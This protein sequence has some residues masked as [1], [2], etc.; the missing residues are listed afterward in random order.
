MN[1]PFM[2]LKESISPIYDEVMA[3]IENLIK[4]TSFIGGEE[5]SLFEDE[6]ADYCD[7]NHAVGCSNGTDAIVLAL[8]VLNIGHGDTV[9]VPA[10]TFIA[11]SEAVTFVGAT[12]DFIDVDDD[13]WTMDPIK[14]EEYLNKNK[15][16]NVKAIIPV[17]LYG[18]M[19]NMTDIMKIANKHDIRVIEDSAQAH[20]AILESKG[21]GCWGDIAT[22][23]FYPGKNLGAFGDAG[24]LVTNN[25][26]IYK[27]AHAYV[28][29]GRFPGQK[30]EHAFEGAN[31]R[32]DTI[33][34][35]ILRIKLRFLRESTDK[36]VQLALRY[37]EQLSVLNKITLPKE[38]DQKSH[39]FHLYVIHS[40]FRDLIKEKLRDKGISSGI[41]Y[42]VPLH[43]QPAYEYKNYKIGDFPNS[44]LNSKNCLSLPLWP[45][46]SLEQQDH[47]IGV[48]KNVCQNYNIK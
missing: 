24:A 43:L 18:K 13:T 5:V 40:E 34:A 23:S 20:G 42:P 44:E 31:L 41:H 47:V 14:L 8:K 32:I 15:D 12:V 10:N 29:H 38:G 26:E 2:N 9:L 7:V 3:K 4:N 37:S 22:F 11:T 28:N 27:I 48:L 6:F 33:Q 46:M 35:A 1:V 39:V 21:P 36:K 16:T 17:H 25:E 45:E 30:Y 19:A